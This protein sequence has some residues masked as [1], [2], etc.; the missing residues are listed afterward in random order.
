MAEGSEKRLY[1]LVLE[2]PRLLGDLLRDAR[3][4]E[5]TIRGI[6]VFAE[7]SPQKAG[8]LHAERRDSREARAPSPEPHAQRAPRLAPL[9]RLPLLRLPL[10]LRLLDERFEPLDSLF[11]RDPLLDRPLCDDPRC[12][13]AEAELVGLSRKA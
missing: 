13:L 3:R 6:V 10:F 9:P 4:G 7:M 1:A 2:D 8:G 12:L 5:L 11:P